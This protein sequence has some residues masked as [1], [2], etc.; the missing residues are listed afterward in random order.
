M[1][2]LRS[3]M[4][5]CA[6]VKECSYLFQ[7]IIDLYVTLVFDTL[8]GCA[9]LKGLN[10]DYANVIQLSIYLNQDRDVV[11]DILEYLFCHVIPG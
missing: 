6:D 10:I 3:T 9:D 8:F 2:L 5:W 4:L 11:V 1:L 7:W